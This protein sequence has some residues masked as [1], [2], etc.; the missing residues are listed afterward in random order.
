M[1]KQAVVAIDGPAGAGKGSASRQLA[2]RLGYT[3]ID[4]GAMFRAV[5][6]LAKQRGIG[7]DDNQGLGDLARSLQFGFD[8]DSKH[9]HIIVN[10][11]HLTDVIRT[12]EISQGSSIIC[13]QEQ[14]VKALIEKQRELGENGG[15]VIEGR[16]TT[17]EVFPKAEV[18]IYLT[19]SL[20]ER[21]KRRLLELQTKGLDVNLSEVIEQIRER[22]HRDMTR[23][24]GPL[25]QADDA[26]V[27][28]TDNLNLS[29]V[30]DKLEQIVRDHLQA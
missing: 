30:V 25:K 3:Y 29:Q 6:Y 19:A 11:E 15:I 28:D 10:G 2:D 16:Q 24:H 20:E 22:D 9:Q 12:P 27:V 18:K 21:A 14:L 26:I 4:S 7:W 5:A 8:G 13:T 17:T 23:L 1:H